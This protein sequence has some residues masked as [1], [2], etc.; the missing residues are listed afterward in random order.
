MFQKRECRI[1]PAILGYAQLVR[2][3]GEK[4][5]R[6]QLEI[7]ESLSYRYTLLV[8]LQP[9]KL[10]YRAALRYLWQR[11]GTREM[12][13]PENKPIC[14]RYPDIA[15][16]TDWEQKIWQGIADKDYFSYAKDGV[17]VGGIP[18]RR[19][20]EWFSRTNNN[21]DLWY[22]SWL[23]ELVSGYGLSLYARKTDDSIWPQ[24]V[25]SMLNAILSAPRS[26]ALF[27]V[28]C[29]WE[30]DG[31]ETWLNDD[32]WAG[33]FEEYHTLMMSWTG[34]LMLLWGQHVLPE[35]MSEILEFLAPY[36]AFLRRV[37][38]TDGCIPSWFNPDETPSRKQFRDFN[39][40]TAVSAL[41]LME[42]GAVTGEDNVIRAGQN[43]LRFITDQVLPRMR[44]FD[45]ETFLSC[46]RKAFAMYDSMTAQYPQCNLSQMHAAMA[47][48]KNYRLTRKP[49]DL[50]MAERVADYLCLSQQ[51][52]NHPELTVN[53]F[54]GFCVQNTDNDWSDVR[55]GIIAILLHQLYLETGKREY[56]ERAVAAAKAG[57]A[58]LPYENWAHNGYEG[59]QYDSSILWGGGVVLSAAEYL[60]EQIGDLFVDAGEC[61]GIG[62]HGVLVEAVE[63]D[64]DAVRV[65]VDSC[66]FQSGLA[67]T[68]RAVGK[69]NIRLWL[70]GIDCGM[71]AANEKITVKH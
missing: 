40:E 56:M 11:Y 44:W 36:T 45:L 28:I 8:S 1:S 47:Y 9:E 54:G 62:T 35:R 20:G 43:A 30:A 60:Q 66:S 71:I 17:M 5:C 21:H 15:T 32:G 7:G 19:Q 68:I 67:L 6:I 70:N 69:D 33:F 48:L 58:V 38:H 3:S 23:N 29:Y 4:N 51:V 41:L 52:W 53:T 64:G 27:P 57:F 46:S 12:N 16:I 42:Y 65:T 37:Q 55:E 2:A 61:W 50:E 10:G 24:R 31:S 26:G 25:E 22:G 14:N 59:L 63:A 39:A 13:R 18:G 49:E 34:Y